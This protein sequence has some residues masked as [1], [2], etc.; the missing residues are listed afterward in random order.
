[1]RGSQRP[2]PQ[3]DLAAVLERAE[4]SFERLRDARLLITGGTGFFGRWM[5]ESFIHAARELGLKARADVITRDPGRF[6][7]SAQHIV[8]SDCIRLRRADIRQLA[9]DGS[10]YTHILHMAAE[11]N[12]TLTDPPT[13]VYY[14][15]IVHGTERVLD[16]AR[17]CKAQRLLF[18]SSGAVY[19]SQPS[20]VVKIAEDSRLSPRL[21]D[22]G[23]SYG[24]AKR[25]AEFAC[26][27][28]AAPGLVVSTARCFAFVGPA[29]QLDS[30]YAI[31]NFIR[32]ALTGGRIVITGD[33]TPRRTYMYAADLAIWLWTI[34]VNGQ[35]GRPYN[36][37]SDQDVSILDLAGL[38]AQAV[39]P[40]ADVELLG[41][42]EQRG[43][44]RRY[45]PDIERARTELGLGLT[46][47][48]E[49]AITR[50]I[51]WHRAAV[52]RTDTGS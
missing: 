16:V 34:L 18:V 42:P 14:D 12:T 33:G 6:A 36:V 20:G 31:G 15:V 5:L 2:L 48:L 3:E 23:S 52:T 10:D 44:G 4:A 19:G 22:L 51:A 43:V 28:E 11:T 30:G 39:R 1:M 38:V 45:V 40:Q 27:A 21:D 47:T 24:Q 46:Y 7:S 29:L 32:D 50:T 35:H 41:D 9:A 49:D 25:C 8:R 37:G 26:Y 17:S 13:A